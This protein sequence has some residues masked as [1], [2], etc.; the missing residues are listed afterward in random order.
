MRRTSASARRSEPAARWLLAATL[1][2]GVPPPQP[3]AEVI[4]RVLAVVD[5]Q[6]ILLSDVRAAIDLGLVTASAE[7][8]VLEAL[9]NR[10]L[11]LAEVARYAP[12]EPNAADIDERLAAIE[13]RLGTDAFGAALRRSGLDRQR[14]RALLRQDALVESYLTQ[15]F[16]VTAMPTDEQVEAYYRERP[17]EFGGAAGTEGPSAAV[18]AVVRERLTAERRVRLVDE[19]IADLRRRAQITVRSVRP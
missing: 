6:V 8:A 19:W 9:V 15:R 16:A 10:A 12:P 14:L 2:L 13:A 3:A 11:V 4:D 5:Q 7:P 17:G 18:L 1:L